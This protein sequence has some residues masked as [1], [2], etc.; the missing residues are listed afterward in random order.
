MKQY[1]HLQTPI[2]DIRSPG[3]NLLGDHFHPIVALAAPFFRMAPTPVTLL[4]IQALLTALSVIPVSRAAT[5]LLGVSP[6]RMIG[7]AYGFSW[8]LQAMIDFDF[9]ELAFAVPLLACSL[10]ALVRRKPWG[11]VLWALPL[12][13][14]KEDQGFTV[15]AI[16]LVLMAY[17]WKARAR[18][19]RANDGTDL[20]GTTRT[21]TRRALRDFAATPLAG[22]L[23]AVW[24]IGWS[25]AAILVIIPHF[26]MYHQYDYWSIGGVVGG[27]GN[28]Q[29]VLALPGQLITGSGEK[30]G[31]LALLLLPVAFL[32][33][34][35]P[36]ALVAVPDLFLRFISTSSS[37]WG[38]DYHYNAPLM[39]IVFIAA[40]DGLARLR[41]GQAAGR[42]YHGLAAATVRYAPP[43]M[44]V[45]AIVLAFWFPLHNLW[46][47]QTYTITGHVQAERAAM[48]RVP[49]GTTVEASVT[50]AASLAARDDAFAFGAPGDPA[51]R[52]IVFDD[53]VSIYNAKSVN[54]AGYV[55]RLHPGASYRQIFLA[56]DVYVFR[57]T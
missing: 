18:A 39:P 33:L 13:F 11:A 43:S 1:A 51:P 20:T 50:M 3:F 56:D 5:V 10:S 19:R 36:V 44:V 21:G 54:A 34:R 55:R 38:L 48:A 46:N 16:G 32:A 28:S 37:Y 14:V 24:G 8:G 57:R 7:A 42:R 49:D 52:Y 17:A 31:T 35:S 25:F 9:H 45:I 4:V 2:D 41:A 30:L 22:F 12:V 6:G 29:S 40:I 23:L 53:S 47:P 26:N 27:S 15:A